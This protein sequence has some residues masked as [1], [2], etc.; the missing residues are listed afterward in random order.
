MNYQS[1]AQNS[2]WKA[3]SNS[4]E[5]ENS[6]AAQRSPARAQPTHEI[7]PRWKARVCAGVFAKETSDNCLITRHYAS[8]SYSHILCK[9]TPS[10]PYL[11]PGHILGAP[12]RDGAAPAGTARLCRPTER[13][14]SLN[15]KST[16]IAEPKQS[17]TW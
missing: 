14:T 16:N 17:S 10:L 3:I 12:V 4:L 5:K 1:S 13:R 2:N 6:K 9:N 7:S 8:Y 11:Y 15:N